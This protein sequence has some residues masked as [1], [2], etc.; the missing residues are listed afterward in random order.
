MT[1]NAINNYFKVLANDV[2]VLKRNAPAAQQTR[3][4]RIAALALHVFAGALVVGAVCAA[5]TLAATPLFSAWRIYHAISIIAGAILG[6]DFLQLAH[7]IHRKCA[8]LE[9]DNFFAQIFNNISLAAAQ[10]EDQNYEAAYRIPFVLRDCALLP[11][12][13]REVNAPAH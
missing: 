11:I 12:F 2:A 3:D 7:N 1:L 4:A 10:I 5:L 6:H 13:A 9:N 8:L